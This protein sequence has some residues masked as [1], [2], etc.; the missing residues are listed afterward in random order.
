MV[1]QARGTPRNAQAGEIGER[2]GR[3]INKYKVAKHFELE[4]SD[5]SFTYQRKTEQIPTE[6]ALDGLYVIR[7]PPAPNTHHSGGRARLQATQD[8]R[9][10]V[11]H[12][13]GHA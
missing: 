8:G 7:A 5:G 9:A 4:I 1:D 12:D 10:R 3:V 2:A 11:S 6:A 13:Q